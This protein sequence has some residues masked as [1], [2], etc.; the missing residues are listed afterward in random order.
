M[1]SYLTLVSDILGGVEAIKAA[2]TRYLPQS[3][4]EGVDEYRM[5]KEAAPWRPEFSDVLRALVSK[6]FGKDV[7]V[8]GDADEKIIGTLNISKK[9]RNNGLV[10][11]V[12]G[13][14]NNLTS[15][16]RDWF[17]Y[18]LSRSV[19]LVL[20]DYPAMGPNPT[21]A[22]EA[23]AGARPYWLHIPAESVVALYT[24]TLGGREV[25]THLRYRETVV[26]R[27]GFSEATKDRI[28]VYEPGVWQIWERK[29]G[30]TDWVQVDTGI[31]SRGPKG[32]QT[33]PV[34]IFRTGSRLGAFETHPPLGDLADMQIELYKA[35]ARQEEILTFA[36]SPML[37]GNGMAPPPKGQEI[38]I[39]PREVLFA[40]PAGD[41]VRAFWEYVQP[42]AANITEI[43]NHVAA[44]QAD[45]RRIG[46]QPLL[47]GVGNTTA[48][49]QAIDAAK[50]HSSVKAWALRLNDAIEQAM[51]FTCEWLG[52]EGSV[53]TEV[54]TDFSV[55]P[56][57]KAPLE[58]LGVS[59]AAGD[60]SQ[61]TFWQ[62]LQRFDVLPPDFD[63][64]AEEKAIAAEPKP[65][66]QED[67]QI[68]Q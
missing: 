24:E 51:V 46:M 39:G 16:A 43:R 60:L 37:A 11:D 17:H 49:G 10:D 41:G 20:V 2:G 4:R 13:M 5:R 54:S 26:E 22:D 19:H 1:D 68:R 32:I 58:A 38:V 14:S 61:R 31:F 50:A 3:E 28:R 64:E 42:A 55:E 44:V 18:G 53:E 25:V 8:K 62:Q 12:D 57:A 27:D 33:V 34:V 56:Y 36:S 65:V 23:A 6:P 47:E 15:F 35:L 9:T 40:P 29:A 21:R 30:S 45:M 63:P 59:R 7:R 66:V 48:T 52:I 67:V